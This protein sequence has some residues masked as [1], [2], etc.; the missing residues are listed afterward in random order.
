LWDAINAY[1][2]MDAISRG[3]MF[4]PVGREQTLLEWGVRKR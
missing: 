4:I 2:E 3:V 1:N